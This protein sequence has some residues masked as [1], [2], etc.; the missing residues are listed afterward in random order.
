MEVKRLHLQDYQPDEDKRLM[1]KILNHELTRKLMDWIA[2]QKIDEVYN[3]VYE[4][5]YLRLND[6]IAPKLMAQLRIACE[7]VGVDTVPP[8]Y[9]MRDFSE[10]IS[11]GGI[12]EPFLLLSSRYLAVLEAQGEDMLCAV[13]TGQMA[14]IRAG[15][16]KGLALAWAMSTVSGLMGLNALLAAALEALLNDWKRCRLYTCDRAMYLVLRNLPKALEAVLGETAPL[17]ILENMKVGTE[18]DAYRAQIDVF[19]N[20]SKM[21]EFIN[22]AN[23]ALSDTSWLPLRCHKL[24]EFAAKMEG[25]AE[26]YA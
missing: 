1:E 17:D 25:G 15:H 6:R 12:T 11:I 4:S 9:L 10:T 26:S 20:G 3:T 16:H 18:A 13:L 14:G 7:I 24:M 19:M 8:V 21:D 23:S 22:Y 2:E 5:S